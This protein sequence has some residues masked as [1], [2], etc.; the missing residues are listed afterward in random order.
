MQPNGYYKIRIGI[1]SVAIIDDCYKIDRGLNDNILLP[2]V[3][4]FLDYKMGLL[5]ATGMNVDLEK[6]LLNEKNKN[7]D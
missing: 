3:F 2:T 7:R 6:N 1:T 4:P 5:S